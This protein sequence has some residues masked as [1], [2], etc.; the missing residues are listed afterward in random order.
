MKRG[1]KEKGPANSSRESRPTTGKSMHARKGPKGNPKSNQASITRQQT[2]IKGNY[3][4]DDDSSKSKTPEP[5][6][7]HND[8]HSETPTQNQNP[9]DPQSTRQ[10]PKTPTERTPT[11]RHRTLQTAQTFSRGQC[12][13]I[14]STNNHRG[15]ITKSLISNFSSLMPFIVLMKEE[16]SVM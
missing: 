5:P 1:C 6:P 4:G 14:Y 11:P 15:M 7:T 3:L 10:P 8:P 12:K 9:Q 13:F 16:T 2:P